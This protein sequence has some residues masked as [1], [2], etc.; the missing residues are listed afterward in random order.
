MCNKSYCCCF[1]FFIKST[2]TCIT[3]SYRAKN[4]QVHYT[5]QSNVFKLTRAV[6]V[7]NCDYGIIILLY[8]YIDNVYYYCAFFDFNV[9][10]VTRFC[11]QRIEQKN[12]CDRREHFPERV[13]HSKMPRL[14]RV[15]FI[16]ENG[17]SSAER[18]GNVSASSKYHRQQRDA[19]EWCKND[20]KAYP[21]HPQRRFWQRF[22]GEMNRVSPPPRNI[23]VAIT[24]TTGCARILQL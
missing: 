13:S 10:S 9:S 20:K 5:S 22:V 7:L 24:S 12:I 16:V 14:G 2:T 17:G 1:L 4:S 8:E 15:I 18:M 6:V 23:R 3:H 21:I 11:S 19:R